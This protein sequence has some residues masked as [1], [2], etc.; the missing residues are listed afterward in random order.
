MGLDA[1]TGA[2]ALLLGN[3]DA[4]DQKDFVPGQ[5]LRCA[6]GCTEADRLWGTRPNEWRVGSN[7]PG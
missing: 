6:D 4:G 5:L 7:E 2:E 1:P 3:G